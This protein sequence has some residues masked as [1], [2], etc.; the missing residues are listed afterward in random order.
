MMRGKSKLG[1]GEVESA[2]G[3]KQHS[4]AESSKVDGAV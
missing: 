3:G 2:E 1:K 4:E